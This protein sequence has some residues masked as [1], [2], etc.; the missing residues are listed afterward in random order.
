M[1]GQR[2]SKPQKN[3]PHISDLDHLYG[4]LLTKADI[5]TV[6]WVCTSALQM[7]R[8]ENQNKSKEQVRN[9]CL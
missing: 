7:N 1:I 9:N 5:C 4:T 3:C 8:K 6:L 2:K